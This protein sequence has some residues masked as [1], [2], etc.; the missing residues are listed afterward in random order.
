MTDTMKELKQR[1]GSLAE[2]YPSLKQKAEGAVTRW[3]W[4]SGPI[5]DPRPFW[6]ERS[7]LDRGEPL[8]AKPR[9]LDGAFEYGFDREARVAVVREYTSVRGAF[10][11]EFFT[12]GRAEVDGALLDYG[13]DKEPLNVTR[14]RL[15]RDR[16][17]SFEL[18]GEAGYSRERYEYDGPRLARIV[19]DDDEGGTRNYEVEYD[20]EGAVRVDLVYP[21]GDREVVWKGKHPA[22][23]GAT[24]E[25]EEA[26]RRGLVKEVPKRVKALG[27]SQPAYCILLVY[28]TE[29]DEIL[30]P[31]VGV[32]LVSERDE[33]K[34][35][36]TK[37]LKHL[38]WNP[39]ELQHFDT[40]ELELEG[41]ALLRDCARLNDLYP[42]QWKLTDA[43]ALLN[44]AARELT[45]IDWSRVCP[46]SP[47]FVVLAV[48]LDGSDVLENLRATTPPERIEE[49]RSRGW[50]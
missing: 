3:E 5:H 41:A 19:V 14:Q 29:T 4:A 32:G 43:R 37:R 25:I 21:R 7:G 45:G 34:R 47:D 10:Y 27:L 50:L 11:E 6:I 28:D 20:A 1:F 9:K 26:V 24:A 22:A 30:P 48:D 23:S 36:G 12:Y 13:P 44:E 16:I 42:H 8:S 2:N 18:L 31:L 35:S 33:W 17:V 40:P 39:A 46:T 15:E 49:L 38:L